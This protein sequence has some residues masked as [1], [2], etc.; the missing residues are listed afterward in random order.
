MP[1]SLIRM[2]IISNNTL[3]VISSYRVSRLQYQTCT[4]QHTRS[5]SSNHQLRPLPFTIALQCS[6]LCVLGM[7]CY[8]CE[9][10]W[11]KYPTFPYQVEHSLHD[12]SVANLP[13][14]DQS[15]QNCE[16]HLDIPDGNLR[17]DHP[18]R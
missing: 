4:E 14:L 10:L 8:M 12:I 11:L 13:H 15:D 7:L 1:Q 17:V 16:F 6:A 2:N 5:Q 3:S 9:K 18:G